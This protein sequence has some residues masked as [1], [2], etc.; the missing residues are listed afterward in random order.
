MPLAHKLM[1][2]GLDFDGVI[3]DTSGLKRATALRMFGVEIPTEIFKENLVVG[4]GLLTREQYRELMQTVCGNRECGLG[5]DEMPGAMVCL[6]ELREAGHGMRV[7]T[8][9]EGA[10][11]EIAREWLKLRGL[12]PEFISVG[13]GH[14]KVG[15]VRG[16]DIFMD[17]DL[18]K[19]LPLVVHLPERLF[20]FHRDYNSA[21]QVPAGIR[22]VSDWVKFRE[23]LEEIYAN[24]KI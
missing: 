6:K 18:N 15:A 11:L 3:A 13:Y 21:D 9:R 16:M 10:E 19:L 17:D 7:V 14:D 20:L 2:I 1:N 4:R 5:M 8:S 12:E 22:R 24:E 23:L